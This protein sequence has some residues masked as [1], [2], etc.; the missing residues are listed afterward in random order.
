MGDPY[1][2]MMDEAMEATTASAEAGS[3]IVDLLPICTCAAFKLCRQSLP[4][5][6]KYVLAWFPGTEFKRAALR[7]QELVWRAHHVP[8]RMAREQMVS[9]SLCTSNTR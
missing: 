8:Y 4:L 7:G 5:P 6:V 9:Y 2:T 3:S 1:V